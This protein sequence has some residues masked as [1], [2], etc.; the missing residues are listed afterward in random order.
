MLTF[1]SV[2][3]QWPHTMTGFELSLVSSIYSMC[4]GRLTRDRAGFPE[5]IV[6]GAGT[7]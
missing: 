2:S 6:T 3:T 4:G 1:G 7:P 5:Q